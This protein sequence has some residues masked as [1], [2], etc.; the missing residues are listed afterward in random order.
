[1]VMGHLSLCLKI[2]WSQ[3]ELLT[4]RHGPKG[5]GQSGSGWDGLYESWDRNDKQ[6]Q[7]WV[8]AATG[9]PWQSNGNWEAP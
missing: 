9:R 6:E 7:D 2:L 1:M 8:L 4:P 5:T 3:A